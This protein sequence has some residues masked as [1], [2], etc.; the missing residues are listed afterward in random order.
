MVMK[1]PTEMAL[2][3]VAGMQAVLAALTC[4]ELKV[5]GGTRREPGADKY[6]W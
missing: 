6:A 1:E 4:G 3:A 5:V 2:V